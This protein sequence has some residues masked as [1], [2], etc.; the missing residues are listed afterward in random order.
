MT[1]IAQEASNKVG[2]DSASRASVRVAPKLFDPRLSWL[3]VIVAT[4]IPILYVPIQTGSNFLSDD[5]SMYWSARHFGETGKLYFEDEL[6][7]S[8][9]ENL[10]HPRGFVTHDG[11]AVPYNFIGLPVLYGAA[12]AVVGEKAEYLGAVLAV[13][14]FSAIWGALGVLFPG[15]RQWAFPLLFLAFPVM[16]YFGRPY[17]NIVPALSFL[18]V[19]FYF[20]LRHHKDPAPWRIA[21]SSA[22]FALGIL[23]RYPDIIFVTPLVVVILWQTYDTLFSRRLLRDLAIYLVVVGVVFGIPL[24]VF[25]KL[26]Y[27]SPFTYGYGLFNHAYYPDRGGSNAPGVMGMLGS[28]SVWVLPGGFDASMLADSLRKYFFQL[29]PV[30]LGVA[31]VGYYLALK[32]KVFKL[33]Y[34]LAYTAITLYIL[35]YNGSGAVWGTQ[36]S[37][38]TVG[39]TLV[40]YWLLGYLALFLAAAYA[41]LHVKESL[42]Q[43]LM[44]AAAIG[45]GMLGLFNGQDSLPDVENGIIR[46]QQWVTRTIIPNTEEDAV[47]YTG[48]S[49]KVVLG[50]RRVAAWF[51]SAEVSFFDPVAVASSMNRVTAAGI[52]VYIVHEP[53]ADLK[54]LNVELARY[55]LALQGI[56][57]ANLSAVVPKGEETG[58]ISR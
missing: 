37:E 17:M 3:V 24:L 9:T 35:V 22:F 55:G 50:S 48:R 53:D 41:V 18:L 45:V 57:G 30:L 10:L 27:G 29:T 46:G 52:P 42:P 31:G 33:R 2:P 38:P 11:R 54:A 51:N 40:R 1:T 20:L 21:T 34:L 44:G 23:C 15:R 8:D 4:L 13:A 7:R 43:V 12:Y 58:S 19:G 49:D 16:Y 5:M 36:F 26:T 39:H 47:I 32:E 56:K 14:G 25:N 6:T 28:L